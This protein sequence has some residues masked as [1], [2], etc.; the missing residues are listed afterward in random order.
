[1]RTRELAALYDLAIL[2][3]Q[4]A[5]LS[6]VLLPMLS[7]ILE[8]TSSEAICL[9]LVEED[10]LRLVVH[11]GLNRDQIAEKEQ[12]VFPATQGWLNQELDLV[13]RQAH[14]TQKELDFFSIPDFPQMRLVRL[15]ASNYTRGILCCYR[16]SELPYSP[17]QNSTLAAIGEQLG[18]IIENHR[19]RTEAE[20]LASLHERQRLARELHD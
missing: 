13:D 4:S 17:Y 2:G 8:I 12:I 9:H 1:M 11:L 3:G 18:V 5:R 10:H 20:V 16:R 15:R 14:T 7:R 6:D 19:L